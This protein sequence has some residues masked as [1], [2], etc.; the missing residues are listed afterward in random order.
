MSAPLGSDACDIGHEDLLALLEIHPSAPG[1]QR[2]R[3]GRTEVWFSSKV[4]ALARWVVSALIPGD[5]AP[6]L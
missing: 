1:P 4:E 5:F 2:N 6:F 3:Q